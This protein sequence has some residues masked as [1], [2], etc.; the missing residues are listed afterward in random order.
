MAC[1]TGKC[2]AVAGG[3]GSRIAHAAGGNDDLGSTVTAL[4]GL[5]ALEDS[6]LYEQSGYDALAAFYSAAFHISPQRRHHVPRPIRH[7][8]YPIAPFG[9]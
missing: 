6:V 5:Y 1:L 3:A 2:I 7:G 4:R 8:K 9:F